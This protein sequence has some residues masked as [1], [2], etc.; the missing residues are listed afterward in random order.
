MSSN[1]VCIAIV[2]YVEGEE[3]AVNHVLEPKRDLWGLRGIAGQC[4]AMFALRL[5]LWTKD[6][7]ASRPLPHDGISPELEK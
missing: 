2:V 5:P 7:V 1:S 6:R 4:G 3:Y